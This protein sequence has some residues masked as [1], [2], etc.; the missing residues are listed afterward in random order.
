MD[1]IFSEL[2]IGESKT[3]QTQIPR[4]RWKPPHQQFLK[5]NADG[6]FIKEDNAGACGFIVRNYLGEP[7]L[8]GAS[9]ISPALDALS[10]ETLAC[11]FALESAQQAGISW[12]GPCLGLV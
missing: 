7:V 2:S 1:S 3:A 6:S 9:N 5:I 10:A 11:L 4:Q 8:A 12:I